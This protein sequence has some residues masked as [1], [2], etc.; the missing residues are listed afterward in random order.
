MPDVCFGDTYVAL[1]CIFNMACSKGTSMARGILCPTLSML[2]SSGKS[3]IDRH[4]MRD[5]ETSSVVQDRC[6]GDNEGG[7]LEQA[8]PGR[9][10]E[11]S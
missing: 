10:D 1:L 7:N 2:D 5:T 11:T 9:C 3:A 4:N 6:N 8:G